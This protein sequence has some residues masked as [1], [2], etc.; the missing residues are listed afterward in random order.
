SFDP[1]IDGYWH[2]LYTFDAFG[3]GQHSYKWEFNEAILT[4]SIDGNV[5]YS[6]ADLR[7]HLT[8]N[9]SVSLTLQD[10]NS[11]AV[12]ILKS[13]AVTSYDNNPPTV[14]AGGQYSVNEGGSVQVSANGNDPENGP[15]AYAW[16]L[17]NNGS[18]E[19]SGQS[20]NF[21]ATNLDGPS[22][23]IITV[24]VTDNGGLTS[25][26]Q[27]TVNVVNVAPTMGLINISAN[28]VLV[29]TSVTASASFTD[30]GILDTHTAVW[31]WGDGT[32]ANG[33]VT[34]TNGSGSI[35]DSHIY[36]NSGVYTIT[37][38]VTDKDGGQ[39]TQTFQ[40]LSVYNPTSQ[41]LFSAGQKYISPTGAYTQNTSLT[42][43]VQF[44]L[45]YKYQGTVPTGNRQFSMDFN[46][47][48]FH[49]NATTITS[50]V[51]SN[52]I[53]TLKGLGT[54]NG[55]GTYNFL[56]TGSETNNTI[57]IQIKDQSELVVYDTQ[58]NAT[59]T[60]DPITPVTAGKVLAH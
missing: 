21:S 10:I 33:T 30:P 52:D 1:D 45:S 59:D 38:T 11:G 24:R 41:G 54:V 15:L 47:A 27:T 3:T 40:Y 60:T 5:V 13:F 48:N 20:V 16:D 42:G 43:N 56:V 4:L 22:S 35:T 19:T 18:F 46:S 32:T 31:D 14:S 8:G 37:L 53:G 7:G 44:G 25:T 29:N 12:P 28:P 50:L 49:F 57:R 6:N 55:S 36:T 23:H 58:P 2:G 17:D 34:E 51:I 39:A 9:Y 26:S